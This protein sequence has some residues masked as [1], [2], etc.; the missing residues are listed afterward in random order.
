MFQSITRN[1]IKLRSSQTTLGCNMK[2]GW[3]HRYR[4]CLDSYHVIRCIPHQYE[5][6]LKWRCDPVAPWGPK[7]NHSPSRSSLHLLLD[8]WF[9]SKRVH[10]H[11]K[12]RSLKGAM[13]H[14]SLHHSAHPEYLLM[15][16]IRWFQNALFSVFSIIFPWYYVC[17]HVHI[18]SCSMFICVTGESLMRWKNTS[19]ATAFCSNQM[20]N[21]SD[22]QPQSDTTSVEVLVPAFPAISCYFCSSGKCQHSSFLEIWTNDR[23][24]HCQFSWKG[25]VLHQHEFI[26]TKVYMRPFTV[27][28]NTEGK[29]QKVRKE[30]RR[31]TTRL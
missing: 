20:T 7:D 30:R 14:L 24:C 17:M 27:E 21:G 13:A 26:H 15:C 18:C 11:L 9:T 16:M 8:Y 22:F 6:Y 3:A 12:Q 5:V 2:K 1:S 23:H 31:L 25:S 19:H 28:G 10:L 4:K 29:T